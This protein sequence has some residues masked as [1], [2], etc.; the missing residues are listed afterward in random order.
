M[1]KLYKVAF[2]GAG[3]MTK[4][5]LKVFSSI[6]SFELVGIYSRTIEKSYSLSDL[7]TSITVYD[8]I[9]N[10]YLSKKP[11][12]V[13]VSVSELSLFDV[14]KEVFQFPWI[15]LIE[16]PAG[17]DLHN[18]QL[19]LDLSYYYKAKA[20]VALNRR[21]YASTRH[22]LE[23]LVSIDS[24]RI[25]NVFDQESSLDALLSGQPLKVV[26]NWMFANSIHTID[27]FSIFCRGSISS[28][29]NIVPWNPENNFFVCS[30]IS[31][32]SGDIGI[33]QAIWNAPSPW[34]VIVNTNEKR[35]ELRPLEQ[36][37]EQVLGSRDQNKIDIDMIDL[38]FKAGLRVQAENV[39]LACM[40]KANKLP[41]LD[42]AFQSMK[43]CNSIY[44]ASSNIY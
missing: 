1:D 2:I 37:Y 38:N 15:S 42:D 13:V 26:E 20:Y 3:Y 32:S 19:I 27:F 12:V 7:Y 36:C 43:L 9:K 11:D 17:Y 31:Y 28:I 33:Y 5:H 35:F 8:S 39:L 16:K 18:A 25:V 21:H 23:E 30:K 40:G 14:C 29:Q 24:Q 4:E 6:A 10:L 22:I 34:S 41:T 44:F